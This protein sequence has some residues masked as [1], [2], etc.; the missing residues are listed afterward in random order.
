M[1]D[2]DESWV[3]KVGEKGERPEWTRLAVRRRSLK[4]LRSER[5][6]LQKELAGLLEISP[7]RISEIERR[8]SKQRIVNIAELIEALGGKLKLVAEFDDMPPTEITDFD[9]NSKS[10]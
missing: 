4:G 5:D 3:E 8:G 1:L 6:L 9:G 7:A 10:R 2:S